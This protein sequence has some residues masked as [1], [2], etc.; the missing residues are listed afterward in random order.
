MDRHDSNKGDEKVELTGSDDTI[1]VR[2]EP[3][4]RIKENLPLSNAA[5]GSSKTRKDQEM[6]IGFS[7]MRTLEILSRQFREGQSDWSGFKGE[8]EKRMWR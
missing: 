6:V 1:S 4:R 7:K 2:C 5:D 8:R 3:K